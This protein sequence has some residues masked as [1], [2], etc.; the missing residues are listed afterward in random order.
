MTYTT[1]VMAFALMLILEGI[2]P[3]L[4]PARW[5]EIFRRITEFSDGQIR[6]FAL[7][8]MLVGVLILLLFGGG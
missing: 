7:S 2:M 8:S 6:F 5:R 4:A 3:F 1:L